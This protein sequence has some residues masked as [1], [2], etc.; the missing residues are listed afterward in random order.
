MKY[1]NEV[2]GYNSRL[3]PIQAAVL[4]IKLKVLDEWNGRRKA[5]AAQYL[6]HLTTSTSPLTLPFVPDYADPVW[7]LFV[8]RH[9]D[10]DSLQQQ[11]TD[12]GSAP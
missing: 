1:V 7:H 2:Q 8:I 3:N 11:L 5:L 12:A 9:P 10:R 4:L 6:A